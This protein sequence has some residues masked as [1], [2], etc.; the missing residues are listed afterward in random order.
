[1]AGEVAEFSE[2]ADVRIQ[3][4]VAEL[5]K[6]VTVQPDR[7]TVD[8]VDADGHLMIE[9]RTVPDDFERNV[10]LPKTRAGGSPRNEAHMTDWEKE[11]VKAADERR[12]PQAVEVKAEE[13]PQGNKQVQSAPRKK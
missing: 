8:R 13:Q 5:V 10:D 2:D 3:A 9:A 12:T 11:D 1:M 7:R 6:E 4:G